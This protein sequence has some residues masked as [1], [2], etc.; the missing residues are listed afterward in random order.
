MGSDNLVYNIDLDYTSI[1]ENIFMNTVHNMGFK[2]Y[3]RG[4]TKQIFCNYKNIEFNIIYKDKKSII[5]IKSKANS[6]ASF[7]VDKKIL[8]YDDMYTKAG[9]FRDKPRIYN[10]ICNHIVNLLCLW[11]PPLMDKWSYEFLLHHFINYI[12]IEY[13]KK[14]GTYKPSDTI[15]IGLSEK[16]I[17]KLLSSNEELKKFFE[18]TKITDETKK[19]FL[20]NLSNSN[21]SYSDYIFT[22]KSNFYNDSKE[23]KKSNKKKL[24]E[25]TKKEEIKTEVNSE[26]IIKGKIINYIPKCKDKL[27]EIKELSNDFEYIIKNDYHKECDEI[28]NRLNTPCDNIDE[29]N[30]IIDDINTLYRNAYNRKNNKSSLYYVMDIEDEDIDLIEHI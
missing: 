18:Y 15:T 13:E 16:L 30:K 23:I 7:L 26:N 6:L 25:E 1:D 11:S 28:E 21:Y 5:W 14:L 24:Q 12:T 27:K 29:F 2:A 8:K 9:Y 19:I 17:K 22:L 10:V 3:K 20:S 4:N